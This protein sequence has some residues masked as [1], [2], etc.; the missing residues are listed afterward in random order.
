MLGRLIEAGQWRAGDA[1]V[2]IVCDAGYDLARLAYLLADLPVQ[3]LGRIRADRVLRLPAP[4]RAPGTK[5]RPLRHG[6]EFHLA[7]PDTWPEPAVCTVTDTSRCGTAHAMAWDRLH[8][9]LTRRAAWLD[10]DGD[11]PI[12]EGTLIRLTVQWLPGDRT[13]EPI[14]LWSSHTGLTPCDV[15]RLWQAYL[16][17]FDLEHTF[18]LFKQTLGWT[19]PKL[20]DPH[21]ADRW[22]WLIIAAHTQLRLARTLTPTC[23]APGNAPPPTADSPP[24]GSAEHFDTS[25]RRPPTPPAHRN[26]AH[27]AQAAHPAPPTVGGHPA[28]TSANS[29]NAN[30]PSR[31]ETNKPVK[32]QG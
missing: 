29:P 10:H 7:D 9:R 20:R 25:T 13:P 26:P 27:P 3:I 8:P 2:L 28:T 6:G 17:R 16:R 4:A 18:R 1:E 21:A 15:D 12:L 5:G 19:T 30:S 31:H 32:R 23:A 22:T 11:L 24:P 14:W